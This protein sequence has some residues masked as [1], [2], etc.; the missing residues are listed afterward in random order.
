M[1][2]KMSVVGSRIQLHMIDEIQCPGCIHGTDPETCSAYEFMNDGGFFACK[3]WRPST[4]F[5]G[6]G[7]VAIGLPKGFNRTGM[8]EFS[9]KSF[10]YIRLYEKP[11]DMQSYDRFNIP[12]WAMEKDGYLYVRCY[13]P[14]SN[15]LFVDVVKDG[16]MEHASMK[17]GEFYEEID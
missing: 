1:V 15:W 12:V 10:V 4:F 14:R 8:V 13:S 16:K 5:G 3:N 17:V 11:E 9:D 2:N 7:R 6:V